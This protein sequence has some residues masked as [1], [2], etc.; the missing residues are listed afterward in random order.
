MPTEREAKWLVSAERDASFGWK[1][2]NSRRI[3]TGHIIPRVVIRV[4]IKD[5]W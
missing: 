3:G 1:Q 2:L 5:M 4:V